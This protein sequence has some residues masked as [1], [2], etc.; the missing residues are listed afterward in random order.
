MKIARARYTGTMVSKFYRGPSGEQYKF[1][2]PENNP[3]WV[4]IESIRDAENL[5]SNDVYE[6]DFT[7]L[8]TT[9]VSFEGPMNNI[10]AM[11]EEMGYHAKQKIAKRFG[12]KA[13]QKEEDLEEAIRPEVEQLAE[14]MEHQ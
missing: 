10:D 13:N 4:D 2:N 12:I 7:P 3:R 1:K 8:G 9:L 14:Q 11:M 5:A 6:V